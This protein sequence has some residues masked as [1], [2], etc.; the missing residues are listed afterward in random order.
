MNL[1][2]LMAQATERLGAAPLAYGH[3]TT[4]AHDEAAWLV[5]WQLGLPLDS[6]LNALASQAVSNEQTQA[7]LA[8]IER[9]ITTRQPAAYLTSEA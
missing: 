7:V 4:N 6:D 1:Q 8:L 2:E 9:R 5:L 3:G